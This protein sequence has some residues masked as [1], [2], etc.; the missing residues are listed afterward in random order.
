M[1]T[2]RVDLFDS[3]YG[4]FTEDVLA[5]IRRET[6]GQDIGQNSWLT[7]DEY[8]RFIAWLKLRPDQ[9]VLEVASG[10]GGPALYLADQAR[11]RMRRRRCRSPAPP[12]TRCCASIP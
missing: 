1:L 2:Q 6:F 7:V 4:H 5:A 11:S 3:T 8:D 9:H 10:S 12:S